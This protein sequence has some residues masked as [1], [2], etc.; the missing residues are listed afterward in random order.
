MLM[1]EEKE[2]ICMAGILFSR[3]PDFTPTHQKCCIFVL[4]YENSMW[5][6]VP[7]LVFIA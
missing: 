5:Q 4:G 7:Q 6:I 1:L 3:F 2:G